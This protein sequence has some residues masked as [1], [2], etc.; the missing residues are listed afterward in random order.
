MRRLP[1]AVAL[2]AGLLAST[3]CNS[4]QA[5]AGVLADSAEVARR[6]TRLAG[7]LAQPDSSSDRGAALARWVLPANLA[8]ISGLALTAD[9]RLLVHDDERSMVSEIDYRR[10]VVV[11]QF[12]VGKQ[13]VLADF[14]GIALAGDALFLLTSDGVLYEFQEGARGAQVEYA[15]HDTHLGHECEFEGVAF[16]PALDA[17][18]MACKHVRIKGALRDSLVIYRWTLPG[19]SGAP[20]TRLTVPLAAVIGANGWKGFHPSDITLAPVSGDYVLVSA[21]EEALV[22]ITPAGAVVAARALPGS[23]QHTEGIAITA[24]SILILSDEA[25]KLSAAVTLFRWR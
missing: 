7:L 23:L 12:T 11:K 19:G 17:L 25:G 13:V 18:L 24:D 14:E 15:V 20:P 2:L 3:A 6:A 4:G 9:G 10:G 1:A 21:E 8:E 16:D 22:E 5:A